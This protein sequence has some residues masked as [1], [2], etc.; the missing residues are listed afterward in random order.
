[1]ADICYYT[2]GSFVESKHVLVN[3]Y[4]I[5]KGHFIMPRANISRYFPFIVLIHF[6]AQYSSKKSREKSPGRISRFVMSKS[7]F[8][9]WKILLFE[10]HESSQAFKII[11]KKSLLLDI[12]FFLEVISK[13]QLP[14]NTL[15]FLLFASCLP[16]EFELLL[17][18]SR[19]TFGLS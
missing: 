14:Q 7:F 17:I 2:L 12:P 3:R 15:N 11:T 4:G 1:M 16:I 9:I 5:I 13:S 8:L 10:S 6:F 18:K 19:F